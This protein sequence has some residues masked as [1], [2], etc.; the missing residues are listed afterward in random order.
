MQLRGVQRGVDVCGRQ[1]VGRGRVRARRRVLAVRR[2]DRGHVAVVRAVRP[3]VDAV[4]ALQPPQNELPADQVDTDRGVGRARCGRLPD[5]RGWPTRVLHGLPAVLGVSGDRVPVA[6]GRQLSGEKRPVVVR[7]DRRAH[8]VSVLGRPHSADGRR[9]ARRRGDQFKRVLGRPD[10]AGGSA[11]LPFGQHARRAGD[12]RVR[13]DRRHD[14]NVHVP[15][16]GT[17]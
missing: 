9:A 7:R 10:A 14:A 11:V 2:A 1:A 3:P 15:I 5:G 4:F 16:P 17:V 6:R 8:P 12:E 13:Q